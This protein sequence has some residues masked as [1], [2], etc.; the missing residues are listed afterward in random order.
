MQ[1]RKEGIAMT[2]P[3]TVVEQ[4]PEIGHDEAMNL[5]ATEY[6]RV[7]R[8]ADDLAG[9]DWS[10]RTDCT[11]RD[12][13]DMLG[14]LLGMYELQADAEEQTR[15][16]KTAAG[17][18]G[19]TG[20]IPLHEL[21]ALQVREHGHLSTAEL[22]R[23]LHNTAPRGLTARRATTGE[24]RAATYLPE[25]PGEQ[26]WTFGDLVDIIHTR[27]SWMHRI[28]IGRATGRVVTLSSAHDGRIVA[29]VVAEWA[30]RHREPFTLTLTGVAGGT[31]RSRT[32]G[33][34][35]T[36]D[37]IEFCRIISGRATAEGLL[38]TPVPF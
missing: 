22:R 20:G 2:G 15:Q 12:V 33:P 26:P 7:L 34:Q 18:A 32:G 28:D 14:H 19:Q 25:M 23:S 6:D 11:D 3:T 35:N 9:G 21:T 31:Y 36:L 38:N 13:R 5:A 10:R 30:R 1:P 24:Q 8:L 37:A 29:D 27:D 17:I 16:Y 4:I